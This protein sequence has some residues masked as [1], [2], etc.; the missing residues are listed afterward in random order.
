MD[1][2]SNGGVMVTRDEKGRVLPGSILNPKGNLGHKHMT[3]LLLDAIKKVSSDTGTS[4]DILIVKALADKAKSGDT[5]AIDMIFER[6]D[7][8]VTEKIDLNAEVNITELTLEEKE[9]LLGLL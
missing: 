9:K 7:G 3:T 5:K 6:S 4:D 2:I 8:K 1:Q